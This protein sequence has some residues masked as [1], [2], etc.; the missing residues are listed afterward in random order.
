VGYKKTY[1]IGEKTMK[2]TAKKIFYEAISAVNP[3]HAVSGHI[4]E[5]LSTYNKG[6]FKKLYVIG[7]GK[8]SASMAQAV[9]D[10][11]HEIITDGIIIT[12][13]DH[14]IDKKLKKI[15]VFE[16]SHPVPCCEGVAATEEVV[17]LVEKA[18]EKTLV[19]TLISGGG[20]ALFISPSHGISLEEKQQVT[21]LLLK[22][23]ANINELNCVR[24]LISKVKGGALTKLIWPATNIS[25]IL[26][27]V[28]GDHL[29]V[30]ASGPTTHNPSSYKEALSVL[31]KYELTEQIPGSV[32][33]QL[34][35][36]ITVV[37]KQIDSI[38][39]TLGAGSGKRCI[40]QG[41]AECRNR[42]V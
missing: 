42:F 30:I 20:S 26:S 24:K 28:M 38:Y 36:G 41:G 39:Q 35:N 2:E 23:G 34:M 13:H 7:F 8:A 6:G 25:L 12:K 32:K 18:D 4:D 11:L 27:D 19:V 9:E 40:N 14:Y 5:I 33:E 17:R 21:S 31:E 37:P 10:S 22:A 29:D 3:Y 1:L 15:R 16:A